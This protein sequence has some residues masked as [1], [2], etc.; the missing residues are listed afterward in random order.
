MDYPCAS[1]DS[2]IAQF[3]YLFAWVS[4]YLAF[5]DGQARSSIGGKKRMQCWSDGMF[6]S[7]FFV[8]ADTCHSPKWF[9]KRCLDSTTASI[10]AWSNDPICLG[11]LNLGPWQLGT[12]FGWPLRLANWI[13]A[14]VFV[15][16][17]S[18]NS[19]FRRT[20]AWP[21]PSAKMAS[22]LHE[23]DAAFFDSVVDAWGVETKFKRLVETITPACAD[24]DVVKAIEDVILEAAYC[25]WDLERSVELELIGSCRTGT[26]ILKRDGQSDRD[27]SL[28]VPGMTREEWKI[29]CH[30]HLRGHYP[31][32]SVGEKAVRFDDAR[33][34]QSCEI[35]SANGNYSYQKVTFP[36]LEGADDTS[37][38]NQN[39]VR[40]YENYPGAKGT[41]KVLKRLLPN[42]KGNTIEALVCCRGKQIL[43][44]VPNP[45][46]ATQDRFGE[47][48]FKQMILLFRNSIVSFGDSNSPL[49]LLEK[50]A[51][52]FNYV[53]VM[54]QIKEAREIA[55][56][57]YR[58]VS[59]HA[60]D[61]EPLRRGFAL[62]RVLSKDPVQLVCAVFGAIGI[63]LFFYQFVQERAASFPIQSLLRGECPD[64][65]CF[66]S[67]CRDAWYSCKPTPDLNCKLP[68]ISWTLNRCRIT[69]Y[70]TVFFILMF[71]HTGV[72]AVVALV[73]GR[74]KHQFQHHPLLRICF[75]CVV[76]SSAIALLY[77]VHFLGLGNPYI[78]Y[79]KA[80][81]LQNALSSIMSAAVCALVFRMSPVNRFDREWVIS[82][83]LMIFLAV[84]VLQWHQIL[85]ARDGS[86][87][88]SS[89]RSHVLQYH[90]YTAAFACTN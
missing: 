8:V 19:I 28:D 60:E 37:T 30:T 33:L 47:K 1:C 46:Y 24:P 43:E 34:H 50:D 72:S 76:G 54:D 23:H 10:S 75:G 40:F 69:F 39:R 14:A 9:S 84:A 2:V 48:L 89:A 74:R 78:M 88:I 85:F 68:F 13:A 29:F 25:V 52:K 35:T 82:A 71:L 6:F 26:D 31:D 77:Y 44:N 81:N 7:T 17:V 18:E 22:L 11:A 64:E 90:T 62:Y 56:H 67:D 79:S 49:K 70:L 16:N 55:E 5:A 58:E 65:S 57:I 86:S 36:T 41:V 32:L 59:Q 20:E 51:R 63:A 38:R 83:L 66:C 15:L 27:Y 3:A 12:L 53:A 73:D 87:Y 45:Y 42:M 4:L 61:R 80:L 21:L